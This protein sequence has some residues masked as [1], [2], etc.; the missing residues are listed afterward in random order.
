MDRLYA[1]PTASVNRN[2]YDVYKNI[3]R[4]R[5]RHPRYTASG[6]SA[7]VRVVADPLKALVPLD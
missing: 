1:C 4:S 5:I 7:K 6:V 2:T 3:I